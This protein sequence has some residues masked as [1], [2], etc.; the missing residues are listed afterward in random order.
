MQKYHLATL[1]VAMIA[2]LQNDSW[3]QQ[4]WGALAS[5]WKKMTSYPMK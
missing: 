1:L 3:H 2:K 4:K 5:T